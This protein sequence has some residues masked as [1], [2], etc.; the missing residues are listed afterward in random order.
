[1]ENSNSIKIGGAFW[2]PSTPSIIIKNWALTSLPANI[3][4]LTMLESFYLSGNRLTTLPTEIGKLCAL[5]NLDLSYNR[6]TALPAEIG[7][8]RS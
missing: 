7:Q 8:L 6:L 5:K 3:E 2:G 4:Q 1:M